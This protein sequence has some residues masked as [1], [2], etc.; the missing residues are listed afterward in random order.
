MIINFEMVKK[1]I[2]GEYHLDTVKIKSPNIN[3]AFIKLAMKYD[4]KDI[5][6]IYI[7]IQGE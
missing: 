3:T 5:S 4:L 1:T 6:N 7:N 2:G